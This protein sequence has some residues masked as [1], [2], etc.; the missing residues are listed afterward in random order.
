VE[1]ELVRT[2]PRSALADLLDAVTSVDGVAP[3]NEDQLLALERGGDGFAAVLAREGDELVGYAQVAH[4]EDAWSV[5]VVAREEN[6]LDPLVGQA[7]DAVGAMGGG[8]VHFWAMGARAVHDTVAARHGLRPW[9]EVRQMRVPLPVDPP[10]DVEVRPFET[11]RDE[12]AWLSANGR[13]FARH[14][15]QGSWTIDDLLDREN[16]AWF[17]PAGFLLHER[18]GRLAG[19]CWTKM[20]EGDPRLGEIYVIGVDPDFHGLGLGRALVLA[21]LDSLHRRGADMG[22]LYVDA[23][24]QA[25]LRLYDRLGFA[26]HHA[27][28]AY[29]GTIAPAVSRR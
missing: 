17:D 2:P 23:D 21:G 15:E 6:M 18:D 13:A 14:P 8:T 3:L 5:G 24:N 25:A 9:R 28:R 29:E 16:Q 12:Q 4:H 27:D 20:H 10:A 19:F 22:M 26:L 7:L 11:G 1:L